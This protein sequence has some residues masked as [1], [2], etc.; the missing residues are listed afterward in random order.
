MASS[1]PPPAYWPRNLRL[2]AGLLALWLAVTVLVGGWGPAL[3]FTVFGWPFGY[4]MA[5]QGALIIYCAIVWAYALVM[6]RRDQAEGAHG[7]D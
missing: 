1:R 7:D 2:I 6:N 3:D 4:W 5:S